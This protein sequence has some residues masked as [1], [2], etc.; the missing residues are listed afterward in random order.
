MAAVRRAGLVVIRRRQCNLQND[1]K[2]AR[3][4]GGDAPALQAQLAAGVRSRRNFQLDGAGGSRCLHRRAEC[5]LPRGD[6]QIEIQIAA[7]ASIQGVRLEFDF[8]EQIA[9]GSCR[10]P[11]ARPGLPGGCAVPARM[12]FGI[13][14]LSTRSL[15]ASRPSANRI[16]ER[17]RRAGARRP[18]AWH[19]D[20][21]APWRDGPRRVHHGMRP[22]RLGSRRGRRALRPRART[23]IRRNRCSR[24]YRRRRV[25]RRR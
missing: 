12:P 22:G 18:A 6:R 9:A 7:V 8:D 16:V 11:R 1:V 19:R 14:T 24:R 25:A 15:D 4:G 5:G 2:V 20:P 23:A 21:A 10:A 17:A 3:R 13:W